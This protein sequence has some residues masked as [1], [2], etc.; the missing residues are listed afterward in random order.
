M[1][2]VSSG[3][4]PS[5]APFTKP[6]GN[7]YHWALSMKRLVS[8]EEGVAQLIQAL[9][10]SG[11]RGTKHMSAVQ[12]LVEKLH[13]EVDDYLGQVQALQLE[14]SQAS[15]DRRGLQYAT[16]LAD[17]NSFIACYR[18]VEHHLH[19][20]IVFGHIRP[21]ARAV[22]EFISTGYPHMHGFAF[23]DHTVDQIKTQWS[24][25]MSRYNLMSTTAWHNFKTMFQRRPLEVFVPA[26]YR[27][28]MED[29]FQQHGFHRNAPWTLYRAMFLNVS[30][31]T[32]RRIKLYRSFTAIWMFPFYLKSRC[33]KR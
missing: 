33:Q 21:D 27:P 9:K 22:S 17:L 15:D 1:R 2:A 19:H 5:S 7:E 30:S 6:S 32:T 12:A 4:I 29:V 18:D 31:R 24:H 11:Q 26:G 14:S 10:M 16:L 20:S 13:T 28:F 25:A 8:S 3:A 23:P